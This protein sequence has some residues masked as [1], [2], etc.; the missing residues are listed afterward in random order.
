[1]G[2]LSNSTE[3]TGGKSRCVRTHTCNNQQAYVYVS[4]CPCSPAMLPPYPINCSP[5]P[6][7][8]TVQPTAPATPLSTPPCLQASQGINIMTE[9]TGYTTPFVF[10]ASAATTS[11]VTSQDLPSTPTLTTLPTHKTAIYKKAHHI[12]SDLDK[13]PQGKAPG[14]EPQMLQEGYLYHLVHPVLKG[15]YLPLVHL[16]L[17]R[18]VFDKAPLQFKGGILTRPELLATFS[19]WIYGQ[20]LKTIRILPSI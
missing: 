4:A 5:R 14:T 12:N 1:M 19:H 15:T 11:S 9:N 3:E 16:F 7:V 17:L 18:S 13:N 10:H 2:R 8:K 6:S 20:R